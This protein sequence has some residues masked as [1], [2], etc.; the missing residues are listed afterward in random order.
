LRIEALTRNVRDQFTAISEMIPSIPR[1]LIATINSLQDPLQTAYNIANLQRME[2]PQSEAILEL[3]STIE[4]LRLLVGILTKESEVLDLGK[5]DPK[6][7]R[8]KRSTKC[9]GNISCASN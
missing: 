2:L 5:K 6:M 7:K 4:K 9:S 3:D 8:A 1:E